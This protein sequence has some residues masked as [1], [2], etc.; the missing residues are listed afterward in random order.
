MPVC[1]GR[2]LFHVNCF[3]LNPPLTPRPQAHTLPEEACFSGFAFQSLLRASGSCG[4]RVE[5][6]LY[7]VEG[8][9]VFARTQTT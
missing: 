1:A 4:S 8:T 9:V 6:K 7:P 3:P 2:G 5:P